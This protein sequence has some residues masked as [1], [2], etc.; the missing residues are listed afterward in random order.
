M[1][2]ELTDAITVETIKYFQA[3]VLPDRLY[4]F[5]PD[6]SLVAETPGPFTVDYILGFQTAMKAMVALGKAP[7]VGVF[8]WKALVDVI[9]ETA[10]TQ[11]EAKAIFHGLVTDPT[12]FMAVTRAA[13]DAETLGDV[14]T[15]ANVDA[16]YGAIKTKVTQLDTTGTK[17]YAIMGLAEKAGDQAAY[18]VT[19]FS[20][21]DFVSGYHMAVDRVGQFADKGA[22]AQVLELGFPVPSGVEGKDSVF[23]TND[24]GFEL[25]PVA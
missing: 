22:A 21:D 3:G 18:L 20:G 12:N 14:I 9:I 5:K 23:F 24:S 10:T 6:A 25:V 13:T 19:F 2:A 16:M 1:S 7:V 11:P 17:H 15:T 4:F 8:L